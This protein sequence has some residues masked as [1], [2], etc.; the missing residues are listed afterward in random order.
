MVA[1]AAGAPTGL[2]G[3]PGT[4]KSN[5]L[6]VWPPTK[7]YF[8]QSRATPEPP[9]ENVKKITGIIPDGKNHYLPWVIQ[10]RYDRKK[11]NPIID[12][13]G[14]ISFV[15]YIATAATAAAAAA[16]KYRSKSSRVLMSAA[17]FCSN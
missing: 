10:E 17:V 6:S 9:N 16:A 5:L 11:S 8:W 2:G 7:L 1:G 15:T 14:F 4:V 12:K 3:G 13:L